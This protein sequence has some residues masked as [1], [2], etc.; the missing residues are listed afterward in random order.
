MRLGQQLSLSLLTLMVAPAAIAKP[1]EAQ[2]TEQTSAAD[3]VDERIEVLGY[4]W[5]PETLTLSGRYDLSRDFLDFRS[6]GNGNITD[7]LTFLPGIQFSENALNADRQ[8]EIRSQLISISGA[9]PWQTGFYFDGLANN[10]RID[11]DAAY[12]SPSSVNDVQGHP[13]NLFINSELVQQVTVFDSNIPAA[14]GGFSGG[15]V[16]VESR[17]LSQLKQPQVKLRYRRSL[18]SW[19]QYNYYDF[20]GALSNEQLEQEA[21]YNDDVELPNFAKQTLGVSVAL[22]INPAHALYASFNQTTSTI[23]EVSLFQPIETVN[24]HNKF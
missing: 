19:N 7:M 10:S 6:Q 20:R 22:P 11:P 4:R 5:F 14:Y 18:S 17:S 13:Q 24:S 15:V 9:E 2:Q 12:R 8:Q 21:Q 3:T 16:D 23:G 1:Q